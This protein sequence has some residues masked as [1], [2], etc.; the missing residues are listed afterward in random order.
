MVS[1]VKLFNSRCQGDDS[2]SKIT[3][4]Q[5]SELIAQGKENRITR[6]LLQA[7]LESPQSVIGK[8]NTFRVYVDYCKTIEEMLFT[9]HYDFVNSRINSSNFKLLLKGSVVVQNLE[10]VQF[11]KKISSKEVLDY[12]RLKKM[13]PAT[14]GEILA[15]GKTYPEAQRDLMIVGLGSLWTDLGGDQYVIYLFG[16]EFEREVNLRPV[17]WSWPPQCGFLSVKCY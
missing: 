4:E 2:M 7:F 12:F 6:E 11:N 14:I 3:I 5:V 17:G 13:R 16:D 9:G 10:L 8:P 15:F 1:D